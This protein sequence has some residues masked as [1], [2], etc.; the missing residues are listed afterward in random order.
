LAAP[1]APTVPFGNVTFR[2]TFTLPPTL[3][4]PVDGH[5][6]VEVGINRIRVLG[7]AEALG[8]SGT[9]AASG[10]IGGESPSDPRRQRIIVS[11]SQ[12]NL[13]KWCCLLVQAVCA[14]LA[15]AMVHSD[16]RL[17][18]AITLGVLGPTRC[19]RSC[20]RQAAAEG[21]VRLDTST[22]RSR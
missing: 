19:C 18:S 10:A 16:N 14:L 17:A 20:R 8:G 15:I 11:Q 21:E 9:V 4:V 13:V 7:V 1:W 2:F 3:R 22:F 12:V 6:L 5:V